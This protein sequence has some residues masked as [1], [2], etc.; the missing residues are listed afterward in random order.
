VLTKFIDVACCPKPSPSKKSWSSKC[1]KY[2]AMYTTFSHLTVQHVKSRQGTHFTV[3]VGKGA[4]SKHMHSSDLP[5]PIMLWCGVAYPKMWSLGMKC[6]VLTRRSA[7]HV[8]DLSVLTHG[9]HFL[10]IRT[11][12]EFQHVRWQFS[13]EIKFSIQIIINHIMGW[14]QI[15]VKISEK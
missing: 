2:T 13:L 1:T 15:N 9:P 5:T 3:Q 10:S 4:F 12:Y 11:K 14:E 7:V 6:G 8:F